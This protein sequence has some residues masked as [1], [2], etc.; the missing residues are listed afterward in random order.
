[1]FDLALHRLHDHRAQNH[2]IFVPVIAFLVD[3]GSKDRSTIVVAARALSVLLDLEIVPAAVVQ[4][5]IALAVDAE[6]V[7]EAQIALS[8]AVGEGEDGGLGGVPAVVVQLLDPS[9]EA[10]P[11]GARVAAVFLEKV[12]AWASHHFLR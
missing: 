3:I 11:F 2:R 8:S 7:V 9:D 4:A 5:E 12:F 10:L 6:L 1:M